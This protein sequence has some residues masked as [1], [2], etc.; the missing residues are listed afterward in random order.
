MRKLIIITTS[1]ILTILLFFIIYLSI[2]GIKTDNFNTFINNK[3]KK[4]NSNLTLKLD[5]VFIKLNLTQASININSNNAILLNNNNLLKIF[6]ID[7]NLN[8]L[9][10]IKKENSI[11]NIKIETSE[12]SI[13]DI[14][15][16]LNSID[17][18]LSRFKFYSQI[19]KGLIKFKLDA[20]FDSIEDKIEFLQTHII[21]YQNK[22]SKKLKSKVQSYE[23]TDFPEYEGVLSILKYLEQ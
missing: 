15:S 21:E 7:I 16:L 12:N 22:V 13:N 9:K 14:T 2:Y 20:E 6:N 8:A 18:D 17:Y 4:Y 23:L 19:K 11:K 3:V 5:D 10:F 1:A